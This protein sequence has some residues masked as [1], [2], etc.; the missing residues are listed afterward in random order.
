MGRTHRSAE[1]RL[2][3]LRLAARSAFG[4]CRSVAS[5]CGGSPWRGSRCRSPGHSRHPKVLFGFYSAKDDREM[6]ERRVTVDHDA[7]VRK[8][9]ALALFARREEE[10]A[11]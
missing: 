3:P 8:D 11:H 6:K 4:K 9:V 5:G 1:D 2:F 10:R 7:R